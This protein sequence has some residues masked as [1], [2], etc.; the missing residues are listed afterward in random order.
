[1]YL[2]NTDLMVVV[3]ICQD[4]QKIFAFLPQ[5]TVIY[6][7]LLAMQALAGQNICMQLCRYCHILVH[8]ESTQQIA[9]YTTVCMPK[10]LQNWL[11]HTLMSVNHNL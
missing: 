9:E 4:T 7:S 6:Y 2:L 5:F 8:V 3:A 10:R 11:A 1:M